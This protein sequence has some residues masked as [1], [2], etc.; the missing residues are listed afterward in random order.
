MWQWNVHCPVKSVVKAARVLDLYD[1]RRDGEPLDDNDFV[2]SGD[3]KQGIRTRPRIHPGLR[4]AAGCPRTRPS[5]N[6]TARGSSPWDPYFAGWGL[7]AALLRGCDVTGPAARLGVT[8]S[9]LTII[10]ARTPTLT[11]RPRP[12]LFIRCLRR[13]YVDCLAHDPGLVDQAVEVFGEDRL[14][15]GSD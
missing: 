5:R 10:A 1:R 14:V 7:L 15:L 6:S 11:A 8:T 12:V 2:I 3:E 9:K 4:C 13:T